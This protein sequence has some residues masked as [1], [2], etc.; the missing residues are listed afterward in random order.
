MH[1][2]AFTHS[3]HSTCI[4]SVTSRT[5]GT[6]KKKNLEV[7][8]LGNLP[9]AVMEHIAEQVLAV[10]RSDIEDGDTESYG[11]MPIGML[12]ELQAT[13]LVLFSLASRCGFDV[14]AALE[15]ARNLVSAT[16]N[17]R[18]DGVLVQ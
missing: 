2:S 7:Y 4:G 15:Q 5:F 6:M 11:V 10:L 14:Q 13:R 12:L 8:E 18:A 16:V 3:I 17:A 9:V 1:P